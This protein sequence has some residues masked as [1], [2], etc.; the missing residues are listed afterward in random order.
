[1]TYA[2]EPM[3]ANFPH[4]ACYLG[5]AP[6]PAGLEM[7]SRTPASSGPLP[8]F[9]PAIGPRRCTTKAT[10]ALHF[11]ARST[12]LYSHPALPARRA[13]RGR[14]ERTVRRDERRA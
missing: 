9:R 14:L 11:A 4:A 5:R 10:I 6:P 13:G 2:P 3:P 7:L 8:K 12:P 1:M